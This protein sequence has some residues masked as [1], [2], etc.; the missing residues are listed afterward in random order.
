MSFSFTHRKDSDSQVVKVFH[1]A[2]PV[3]CIVASGYNNNHFENVRSVKGSW[4]TFDN[5]L[6]GP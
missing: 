4:K 2:V 1:V 5:M 3:Y 6:K